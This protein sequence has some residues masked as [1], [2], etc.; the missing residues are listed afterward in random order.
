MGYFVATSVTVA[1]TRRE[2]DDNGIITSYGTATFGDGALQYATGGV[3]LAKGKLGF[4]KATLSFEVESVSTDYVAEYDLT[5]EL[6]KLK[7]CDYDAVADGV[8]IEVPDTTAVASTIVRFK[9][10]GY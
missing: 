7:Y 9:A 3:P 1:L 6:L 10:K 5:N 8:Y 2:S 4:S